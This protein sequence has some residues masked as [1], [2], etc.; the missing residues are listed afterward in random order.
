[1][2]SHFPDMETIRSALMLALRAPSVHNS[3][4]WQWRMGSRSIHLYANP[5]FVYR[6]LI[7]SPATSYS[8]A[9]R[10]S[11]IASSPSLA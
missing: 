7:P 5:N 2:S 1:M 10:H 11:T 9:E 4:P 6:T 8:A 3:Q